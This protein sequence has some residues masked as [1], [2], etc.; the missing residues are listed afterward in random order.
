MRKTKQAC[1]VFGHIGRIRKLARRERYLYSPSLVK[2]WDAYAA[3]A[4]RDGF[5]IIPLHILASGTDVRRY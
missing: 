1:R 4:R 5:T 3:T 2:A